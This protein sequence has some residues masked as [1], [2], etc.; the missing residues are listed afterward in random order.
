MPAGCAW[1]DR[2]DRASWGGHRTGP[3]KGSNETPNTGERSSWSA[4][5]ADVP[6]CSRR[7]PKPS[8]RPPATATS[9]CAG[10]GAAVRRGTARVSS[11]STTTSAT[12][13]RQR[14]RRPP[15]AAAPARRGGTGAHRGARSGTPG[16]IAAKSRSPARFK[17]FSSPMYAGLRELVV[18]PGHRQQPL[19]HPGASDSTIVKADGST[20]SREALDRAGR[21]RS[22]ALYVYPRRSTWKPG[23]GNKED[24]S[25]NG[26]EQAVLRT[27][28]R[29]SPRRATSTPPL[30][31]QITSPR[32][33]RPSRSGRRPTT[34]RTHVL[35]AFKH[36]MANDNDGKPFVLIGHSQGSGHLAQPA[37]GRVR[38][39]S[40]DA[41]P[42]G[43][44]VAH[45]RL[46]RG[47]SGK[48]VGGPSITS[49]SAGCRGRPGASCYNSFGT[50][51]R[52]GFGETPTGRCVL[53]PAA[54]AGE[55]RPGALHPRPHQGRRHRSVP[56]VRP[57]AG[58]DDCG[59][60]ERRHPHLPR[61]RCVG[62]ARRSS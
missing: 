39:R 51:P 23:G 31:H 24:L 14:P 2:S 9:C 38:R 25:E 56:P 62:P 7:H 48:V 37:E 20:R 49:S 30:Y 21:R 52:G 16:R 13:P 61:H 15:S 41:E 11:G 12:A 58:N 18:P 6:H 45:R 44:G 27:K 46:R 60:Q 5:R 1:T 59:V 32:T 19:P 47:A 54:P 10:G 35:A 8:S 4:S 55:R 3:A 28:A 57:A 36:Y 29:A 33:A 50:R 22:T 53:N 34:L 26:V 43:L 40:G 42:P 17:S